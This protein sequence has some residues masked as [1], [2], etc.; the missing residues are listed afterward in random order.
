VNDANIAQ[1]SPTFAP[2][3]LRIAS[4]MRIATVAVTLSVAIPASAAVMVI[5]AAC[6]FGAVA[7]IPAHPDLIDFA[8]LTFEPPSAEDHRHELRSGVPVYLAPSREFPLVNIT[9]SFHGGTHMDPADAIGLAAATAEMMRRGGTT[10]RSADEVDETFDFLAAQVS[11]GAGAHRTVARLNCLTDNLDEA[12]SLFIDM[13]RNPGFAD[14]KLSTWKAT[15]LAGIRQRNDDPSSLAGREWRALMFGRDHHEARVMRGSDLDAITPDAMR[16]LH[17][18][19]FNPANLVIAVDGDFDESDMLRRLESMLDG[20]NVVERAPEPPAPFA[21]PAPGVRHLE[22]DIA[23]GRVFAGMRVG[24]R[25][26][27]DAPA[28]RVLNE[29]LGAGGFTSRIT[30]RIRSDEGL[31]YSAGASFAPRLRWPGEWR[32]SFQTRNETVAL[33]LQIVLEEVERIRT[34]LVGDEE[35]ETAIASIVETFPRTFESRAGTLAIFVDDE[36]TDRPADHWRTWRDRVSAVTAE[37]VRAAAQ[38]HLHADRLAILT[39]GRWEEIA[40]GDI[41]GRASIE[42]LFGTEVEMLPLRDPLTQEPM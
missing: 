5:G 1:K 14:D 11:V 39:V 10:T 30:K 35:L 12:L 36:M 25:D 28:V 15:T 29:I 31:A 23:Q 19:I 27:P 20:W 4:P 18:R 9:F 24:R 34:E 32:A 37:D 13:L 33:G 21:G 3:R 8:P 38:R 22:R 42:A 41:D 26:D 17:P 40:A 2:L 6:A 7:D 16:T